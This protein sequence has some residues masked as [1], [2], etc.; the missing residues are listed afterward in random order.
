MASGEL[1]TGGAS[2]P[3]VGSDS[4][5]FTT[6]GSVDDKISATGVLLSSAPALVAPVVFFLPSAVTLVKPLPLLALVRLTRPPPTLDT[7]TFDAETF[8]RWLV[9]LDEAVSARMAARTVA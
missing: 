8:P 5:G 7:S 9:T 1:T 3:A 2:T 6:G 4:G